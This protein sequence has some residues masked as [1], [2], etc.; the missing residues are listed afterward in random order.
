MWV[1]AG[2]HRGLCGFM[3]RSTRVYMGLCGGLFNANDLIGCGG[4]H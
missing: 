4:G 3:Q 1:Y 2:L